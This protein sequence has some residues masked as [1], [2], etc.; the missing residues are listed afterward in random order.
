MKLSLQPQQTFGETLRSLREKKGMPL[1]KLAALLDIDQSTLSKIERNERRA[2]SGLIEKLSKIFKA[3]KKELH[4][5]FIS[6][7]VAYELLDDE[8]SYDI[9]KVAEEKIE[10]LKSKKKLEK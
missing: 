2:N 9:L 4:I 3:D 6:D 7:K 10:Y 1:R 5:N 8:S